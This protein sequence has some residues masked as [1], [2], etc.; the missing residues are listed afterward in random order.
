[1]QVVAKSVKKPLEEISSQEQLITA[2]V[3]SLSKRTKGLKRDSVALIHDS[4]Y[5]L[6][7]FFLC[8]IALQMTFKMC[9]TPGG[10]S[11]LK[12]STS[13]KKKRAVH[14]K[15]HCQELSTHNKEDV[16]AIENPNA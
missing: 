3:L 11:I 4:L 10:K 12:K 5:T 16:C 2:A 6:Y 13:S 1:M 15:T 9:L 14:V 7:G 8:I